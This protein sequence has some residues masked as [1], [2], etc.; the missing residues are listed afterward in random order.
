MRPRLDGLRAH[1]APL[2]RPSQG[3]G[4]EGKPPQAREG[5]ICLHWLC[6][7]P[8]RLNSYGRRLCKVPPVA[9]FVPSYAH[10]QAPGVT[11][12]Y[13]RA[14]GWPGSSGFEALTGAEHCLQF[15]TR[16]GGPRRTRRHPGCPKAHRFRRE[17]R[18]RRGITLPADDFASLPARLDSDMRGRA[19]PRIDRPSWLEKEGERGLAFTGTHVTHF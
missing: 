2:P 4:L 18:R 10:P 1:A 8:D 11:H 13:H 17:S 19:S 12:S 9:D 5:P 6:V 3:T 14:W 15:T 16:T 7:R